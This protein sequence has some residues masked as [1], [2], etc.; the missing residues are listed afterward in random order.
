[1][2]EFQALLDR[3]SKREDIYATWVALVTGEIFESNFSVAS[4]VSK[5]RNSSYKEVR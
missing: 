4:A 2:Q 1:M 3:L 5:K